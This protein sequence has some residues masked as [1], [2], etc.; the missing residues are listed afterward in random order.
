MVFLHDRA[1]AEARRRFARE[2]QNRAAQRKGGGRGRRLIAGPRAPPPTPYR[3]SS[4]TANRDKPTHHNGPAP[5]GAAGIGPTVDHQATGDADRLSLALSNS[6]E[7]QRLVA[8][9]PPILRVSEDQGDR[10]HDRS[11]AGTSGE[12]T[13][14]GTNGAKGGSSG[15]TRTQQSGANS[16][17]LLLFFLI[18]AVLFLPVGS[19]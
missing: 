5:S 6:R 1:H 13:R 2:A 14:G 8:P 4:A 9:D 3:L 16:N 10:G 19:F 11:K 12:M 17:S 15:G 18:I 7:T